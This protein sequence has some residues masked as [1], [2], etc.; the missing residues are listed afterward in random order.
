MTYRS[1]YGNGQGTVEIYHYSGFETINDFP[2]WLKELNLRILPS[3]VICI[4]DKF[5]GQVLVRPGQYVIFGAGLS[6]AFH[7]AEVDKYYE[8]IK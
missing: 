6:V 4:F 3:N 1:K 2:D 7:K 5:N 8:E